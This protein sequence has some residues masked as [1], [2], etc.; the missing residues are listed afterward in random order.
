[1]NMNTLMRFCII[2]FTIFLSGYFS[3]TP[4]QNLYLKKIS[5]VQVEIPISKIK[6]IYFSD[7]QL[8]VDHTNQ[9][10]EV[11]SFNELR[12]LKFSDIKTFN[13]YF[14]NNENIYLQIFPNPVTNFLYV[15]DISKDLL[16][17][18][19]RV[20]ILSLGGHLIYSEIVY[21]KQHSFKINV[22][23][24]TEGLYILRIFNDDKYIVMKFIKQ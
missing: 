23:S 15:I 5:G 22:M 2:L 17:Q 12:Y 3:S 24:L 11:F 16:S 7:D 8:N 10:K 18:T 19:A 14:V 21:L 20:E 1:M 6:K 9:S 13:T 4:A